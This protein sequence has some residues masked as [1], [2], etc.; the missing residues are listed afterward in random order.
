MEKTG[1]CKF[2]SGFK[3]T[4]DYEKIYSLLLLNQSLIKQQVITLRHILYPSIS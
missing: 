2:L 3:G 1:K 4:Y